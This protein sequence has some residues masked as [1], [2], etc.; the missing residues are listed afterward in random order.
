MFCGSCGKQV[1]EGSGFCPGC[2]APAGG[3][4]QR[5][6]AAAGPAGGP[7]AAAAQRAKLE[8]QFKAGSQDAIK[9][10]MVLLK[11]PVGGLSKSYA[12]FDEGR[13]LMVGAIFGVVFALVLMLSALVGGSGTGLSMLMGGGG[14]GITS[15]QLAAARAAGILPSTGKIMFQALIG[16]LIFAAVLQGACI[17]VRVVFK[18]TTKLA[19]EIYIGGASLLPLALGVAVT[20]VLGL[21]GLY[22]IIPA[23]LVFAGTYMILMLFAGYQR[24]MGLSEGKAALSVPSALV[25]AGLVMSLISGA[26]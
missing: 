4:A 10:F 19:G 5:P 12:L 16:G 6:A 14:S 8:A 24:L 22:R 17:L 20:L 9:A 25:I 3:G 2:G 7:S 13:A 23:V 21:A 26:F 1:P 18:G 15:E 11:D